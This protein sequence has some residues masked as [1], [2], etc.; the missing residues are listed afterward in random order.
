ME[1]IEDI[2]NDVS[3]NTRDPFS[4]Y[5]QQ[6]ASGRSGIHSGQADLQSL[7]RAWINERGSPELL[8]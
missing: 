4:D 3:R 7:T 2:L 6:Y 1:E 5:D 8:P